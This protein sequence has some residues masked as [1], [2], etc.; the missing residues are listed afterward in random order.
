MGM[1]SRISRRALLGGAVTAGLAAGTISLAGCNL[2]GG[3]G[4]G[5]GAV[6]NVWGGVPNE[7]GPDELCK[8]FM[9]ENPDIKVTYTRYVNDEPGN[10]KLD[11]SLTVGSRSTCTSPTA[12]SPCSSAA[13]LDWRST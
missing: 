5:G 7:T 4:G 13:V 11:T 10:L 8:A 6:L 3:G 9:D 1:Q 12:R 2:A